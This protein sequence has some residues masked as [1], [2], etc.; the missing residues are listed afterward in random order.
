M[1]LRYGLP[2]SAIHGCTPSGGLPVP[3]TFIIKPG[4]PEASALYLRMSSR[5]GPTMPPV[6]SQQVDLL[7]LSVIESWIRGRTSCQ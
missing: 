3:D 1:E 4:A 7:G 5:V 2:L 6:G